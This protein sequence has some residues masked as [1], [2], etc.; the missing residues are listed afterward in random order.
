MMFLVVRNQPFNASCSLASSTF[1]YIG[2]IKG[3]TGRFKI[4][5]S[6][7]VKVSDKGDDL[8]VGPKLVAPPHKARLGLPQFLGSI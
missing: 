2:Q 4:Q 3:F 7:G 5:F 1:C 8:V 6:L